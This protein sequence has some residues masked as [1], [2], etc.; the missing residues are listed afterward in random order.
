MDLPN[1]VYGFQLATPAYSGAWFRDLDLDKGLFRT[2]CDVADA[3]LLHD[4]HVVLDASAT[5]ER[6]FGCPAEALIGRPVFELLQSAS[7]AVEQYALPQETVS[8]MRLAVR[9]DGVRAACL[10]YEVPVWCHGRSVKL[11]A[12]REA[13]KCNVL[14][15]AGGEGAGWNAAP[16]PVGEVEQHHAFR[17]PTPV[18]LGIAHDLNSMLSTLLTGLD[19]LERRGMDP[20]VH[21]CTVAACRQATTLV[22]ELITVGMGAEPACPLTNLEEAIERGVLLAARD[23]DVDVRIDVDEGLWPVYVN[24]VRFERVIYNLALNAVQAMPQGGSL[25]VT[26]NNTYVHQPSRAG[27]VA[28]RAVRVSVKDSGPGIPSAALANIFEPY[29][30]TKR[31]GMGIGLAASRDLIL[32]AGGDITVDSRAGNGTTFHTYLPAG[33]RSEPPPAPRFEASETC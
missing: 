4:G 22:G 2:I 14:P 17:A 11:L 25:L 8:R 23:A 13:R 32:S 16:R 15:P 33:V 30:T 28:G 24:E 12:V 18:I 7:S 27:L 3:T 20:A 21:Q 26:A 1:N 5:N 29:F 31:E 9:V 6:L 10:V 19:L